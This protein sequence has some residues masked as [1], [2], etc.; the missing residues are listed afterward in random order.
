M[1]HAVDLDRG[2]RRALQAR[3]EHAPQRVAERQAEAALQRL[4]DD[5]RLPVCGS[6]PA[7]TS[8]PFGRMSSFQFF[9]IM[10]TVLHS[11]PIGD[12]NR[13]G[14]PRKPKR[15]SA[16]I[17]RC[18]TPQ[19]E[20]AYTASA[21]QRDDAA[22]WRAPGV[23]AGGGSDASAFRRAA[24]VMRNRRHVADR[25][26]G[27]ADRLQRPERRLAARTRPC[28]STSSVRMPC[29][30]ALRPASSAATCAA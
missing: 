22:Q 24:A 26:D 30:C 8:R 15:R 6:C 1:Q 5:G 20:P 7:S 2:D 23:G 25:R 9:S 10:R 4:G 14:L 11:R 28:T 18:K 19:A 13:T 3:E 12:R 27:E 21:S 29:S 16:C 17:V